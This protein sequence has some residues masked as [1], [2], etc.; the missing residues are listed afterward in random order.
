MQRRFLVFGS[1]LALAACRSSHVTGP[2]P[3]GDR[4]VSPPGAQPSTAAGGGGVATAGS[5]A[6]STQPPASSSTS[7]SKE[8]GGA[9]AVSAGAGGKAP[10]AA[11]GVPAPA[12]ADAPA[13]RVP[14][15]TPE[16]EKFSF[17]LTSHAA[18][19]RES[20]SEKGFGG[21]LGGIRGADALC[22][23]IA[24]SSSP[25]AGNKTWRAFLSTTTEHAIDRI[26]TGP[27]YD[28][29][30]RVLALQR[31]DLLADRPTS[32]D[33][34]II[35]DFPNETG[36]PNRNPDGMGNVD[37]H[38]ILTGSGTDGK[39]YTQAAEAPA[40]MPPAGGRGGGRGPAPGGG[41]FGSMTSCDGGWT[42]EKATCWNWTSVDPT[43]CPRVGHSWPRQG[44]GIHWISVWNEGGCAPG[45]ALDDR[46]APDGMSVGSFGGYGG[47]YCF[48]VQ[49]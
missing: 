13:T 40:P 5:N 21:N 22:S 14:C 11:A 49:P 38:Q 45:G 44:S 27:W 25:C 19:I 4:A 9:G 46:T 34:A 29:I 36:V 26:G 24:L 31:E 2:A 7:T 6:G 47:F 17:F 48:A 12:P 3:D 42:P 20:G 41:G 35:N 15:E 23:K 30:G 37:N 1:V 18:L 16:E 8:G 33:P 10:S 28:R 32:A 43:G 39:L